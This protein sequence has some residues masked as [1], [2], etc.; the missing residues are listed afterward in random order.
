MS[1]K[2]LIILTIIA[3]VEA[4]VTAWIGYMV[5]KVQ[6]GVDVVHKA[7]N[8]IV[9]QLV[10]EAEEKGNLQGQKDERKRANESITKEEQP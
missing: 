6:R 9:A 5:V 10:N 8:S 2:T 3:L 7:T 4:I 1:D